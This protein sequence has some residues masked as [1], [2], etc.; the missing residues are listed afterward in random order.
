MN[1]LIGISGLPL[2]GT[3]I[4]ST[5]WVLV[6]INAIFQIA[7]TIAMRSSSPMW[8]WVRR[9]YWTMVK[10]KIIE[11]AGYRSFK[12][13]GYFAKY[14]KTSLAIKTFYI[15]N[16]YRETRFALI[17][18]FEELERDIEKYQ[19]NSF[20]NLTWDEENFINEYLK[21]EKEKRRGKS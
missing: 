6:F 2:I 21:Q 20:D 5:F 19:F 10:E 17:S 14:M 9:F 7:R 16:G 8:A 18:K 4:I 1:T 13:G 11:D 3:I 15:K 12:L